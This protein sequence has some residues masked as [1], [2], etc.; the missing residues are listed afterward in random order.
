MNKYFEIQTSKVVS[1]YGGIGSIIETPQGALKIENF[2]QWPFVIKALHENEEYEI[3]DKRL[4]KRLRYHF[5]RLKGFFQVPTNTANR[6]NRQEPAEKK[7][8]LISAEYFPQWW[9]CP[10]CKRFKTLYVW[11][12]LWKETKEKYDVKEYLFQFIKPK[13]FSCYEKKLQKKRKSGKRKPF[14]RHYELEQVRF[15]MTSPHGN[16]RDIPWDKWPGAEKSVRE[17]DG[18]YRS[19]WLDLENPCCDNPD[20]RYI[21]SSK[22]AD[23]IGV[24]IKCENC[25]KYNTLEGLFSL[26]VGVELYKPV[27]RS[28]TS[29]YYPLIINS[30]FLPTREIEERDKDAIKEWI[31]DGEDAAFCFKALRKKYTL[32]TIEIFIKS[33]RENDFEPEILYR[34][35]EYNFLINPQM[36]GEKDSNDFSIESQDISLLKKYGIGHLLKLKR[37]KLVT[38]QTAYTRQ[39][40]YD[41]DLFLKNNEESNQIKFKYTSKWGKKTEYLPAIE[42][43]GEG[44]FISFDP[45][46]LERWF[47]VCRR[48]NESY[49]ERIKKIQENSQQNSY[50]VKNRFNNL[51]YLAKFMLIHTLSHLLIKEFEFLVGYPATSLNERLF[52]DG[53]KMQGVL[54]YTVAGAEGSYGGLISQAHPTQIEKLMKSALFRAKDCA[55]DPVCY[56]SEEQGIGGLNMAAC[57]SC[58]LLPEIACEEFNCFLDRAL[59]V[60]KEFGYFEGKFNN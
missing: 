53:D 48:D 12:H 35:K 5:P 22:F 52:V 17:E 58:V 19:I 40:P 3:H 38:V 6:N 30:I 14:F 2:D 45:G 1:S 37:I 54:I 44:I 28:S 4:L 8:F 33:E 42:S 11:W 27:I 21:R 20:L 18:T 56:N 7:C 57:Y 34:K 23:L 55:S 47:E 46:K 59:L 25:K 39:E 13:C 10:Q 43:Y 32:E 26:R 29:V 31:S 36:T 15:I 16:I 49:R 41:K 50:I 60:D 9:Y 51:K 24:R